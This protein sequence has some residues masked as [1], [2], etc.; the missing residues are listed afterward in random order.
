MVS[1]RYLL[2]EARE[3]CKA[4]EVEYHRAVTDYKAAVQEC[5]KAQAVAKREAPIQDENGDPTPLRAKLE[6]LGVETY[7]EAAE[8]LDE[9]ERKVQGIH[10]DNNAIASYE[11]N[12]EELEEVQA[13]LDDL[14]SFEEKRREELDAKVK[15]WEQRL[16]AAVSKVDVLF[17]KYMAEM[18]N[19]GK[20]LPEFC[21]SHC[22]IGIY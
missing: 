2:Q 16:V 18:G 21:F 6:E 13:Q 10:A 20:P 11:R 17:G 8:A 4:I 22:G 7:A 19:T 12:K 15:P 5:K 9:A 3:E 14:V 1:K